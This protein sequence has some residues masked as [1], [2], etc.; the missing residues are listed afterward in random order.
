MIH[1][2]FET[3]S[4]LN[5]RNTGAFRYARDPST[6]ILIL[7]W[8]ID[9]GPVY[10]WS[11]YIKN[12][13]RNLRALE[14]L[15]ERV[16][17]GETFAAHNAQFEYAIWNH[18]GTRRHKWPKLRIE[19]MDC[20]AAR[21]ATCGLPRALERACDAM[22]LKATKD[23]RG[24][25]LIK[26]FCGDRKPTRADPSVRVMPA[27]SPQEFEEFIQYCEQD[28]RAERG[29]HNAI[30]ELTKSEKRIFWLDL[31][32][33]ERGLQIDVPLVQKTLAIV[34]VLEGK[35][36]D[37]VRELTGGINPTQ[38]AKLKAHLNLEGSDLDNMQAETLRRLLAKDTISDTTREILELRLEGS[39]ASTKKLVSMLTVADPKDGRAR[40]TILYHGAHT[41]RWTGRLIQ[42]QN[43]IRGLLKLWEQVMVFTLLELGDP[44][45][46]LILFDRPMNM[47]AQCMRGFIIAAKGKRLII[48]D[49]SAIEARILFWLAGETGALKKYRQGQD[50]YKW[51]ASVLYKIPI[52]Q[53][54]DEQRRIGKNLILGCGYGLG[55]KKFIEYCDKA[56]IFIDAKFSK[57]AVGAYRAAHPMVKKYW[58]VINNAAIAAVRERCVTR[59]GQVYFDGRGERFFTITLPSGRKLYYLDPTIEMITKTSVNEETGETEKWTSATLTYME[60]DKGQFYRAHTYG[61]KLVENIVQGIARDVMACGMESCEAG[62]YPTVM[63]VHDELISERE[64]GEGSHQEYSGLA[65]KLPAW[66][67]D[68]PIEAKGFEAVRYR[69]D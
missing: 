54:T 52:D 10:R 63:T 60:E 50:L 36:R 37:R 66:I 38:V 24:S 4:K 27:D 28:V 45:N 39:R 49:Y 30:P 64:E 35:I 17:A 33:N 13:S 44:E 57:L 34:K 18:V 3:Y 5:V 41:G 26:I 32:I 7:S 12:S 29:L 65:C 67:G 62:G 9:E 40:G 42:P 14:N 53:V 6:E 16:K 55:W 61:G 15:L 11:P 8:S 2:D 56:G 20:T 46:F 21:A 69:K 51:M 23:K 19:Q 48:T 22:R 47:I 43:F 68:C 25:A 1:A 58:K 59:V 31:R